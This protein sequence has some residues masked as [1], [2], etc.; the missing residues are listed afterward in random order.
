M[1]YIYQG[2]LFNHK[3]DDILPFAIAWTDIEGIMLS[4]ISQTEK[5]KYHYDFT[6]VWNIKKKQYKT[7]ANS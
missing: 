7:K 3:N 5:D 1:S 4:E 2:I 6:H